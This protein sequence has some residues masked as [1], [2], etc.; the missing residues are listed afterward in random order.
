VF[1]WRVSAL[2]WGVLLG[3][4]VHWV[5]FEWANVMAPSAVL[6]DLWGV[7]DE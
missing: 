7:N 6:W 1:H 4:L 5:L 3:L 2:V